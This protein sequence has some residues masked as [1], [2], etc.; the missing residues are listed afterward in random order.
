VAGRGAKIPG[1]RRKPSRRLLVAV[2]AVAAAV[3]LLGQLGCSSESHVA[4]PPPS[5]VLGPVSSSTAAFA[6]SVSAN[7]R[8]LLDQHN[9]PYLLVGDSPWSLLVNRTEAQMEA[10]FA[11]RHARGFDAALVAVI[12]NNNTG[13]REN[14]STYDGIL[15]FTTPGDIATPNPVYWQ[16]VDEMVR[17]AENNGITLLLDPIET[18]GSAYRDMLVSNGVAKDYSY[19]A[20]LGSRYAKYPNIIWANGNDY[21]KSDW[22][23]DPYVT[24][25]ANGIRSKDPNRIQTV[26][27]NYLQS[28]SFDDPNWA[29]YH[30]ANHAQVDL[31]WAY[32]YFPTYDEVLTAYNHKPARPVFMGEANYENE[33]L[34]GHTTNETLL[35]QAYWTM[36]SGATGL[37][38]G[39]HENW[40]AGIS[41][42]KEQAGLDSTAVIE[43]GYMRTVLSTLPWFDLIPDQQH[44]LLT[45]GYGDYSSSGHVSDNAY[46]T[47]A[48]AQDGS[49]AIIYMPTKRTITVDMSM[50]RGPVTARW[51]D[52]TSGT[53]T[54]AA[55]SA[56][57][58]RGSQQFTPGHNNSAN[59][60][61]WVLVLTA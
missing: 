27:L 38:Y 52:P 20:F 54:P 19:G 24:A 1:T 26:E 59:S 42:S 7:G 6:T 43:L 21:L 44:K 41:W 56:L 29:T 16:R 25:V 28:T 2:G 11:D 32:T 9:Q 34:Q 13:G 22:K 51:F 8:Y 12:C 50:F 31:N 37:L 4:A 10:Y 35:R 18:S 39:K 3:S 60:G 45:A 17:L 49:T 55:D 30:D 23:I 40:A 53:Y 61:D 57:A 15:P 48:R 47:A 14:S 58:N 36:T 5:S 46:A 33:S